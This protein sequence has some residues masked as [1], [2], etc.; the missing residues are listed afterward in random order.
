MKCPLRAPPDV[1]LLPF[2]DGAIEKLV[3][4]WRNRR[5]RRLPGLE[6]VLKRAADHDLV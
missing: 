5:D 6:A 2:G 3:E 1:E 4:M